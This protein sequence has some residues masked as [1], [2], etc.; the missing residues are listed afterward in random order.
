MTGRFPNLFLVG[1]MR[2]G[3]TAL[4][5]ALDAHPQIVMS[6]FKEPAF[7]ADPVELAYD[8][9]IVSTAGFAGDLDRYLGLFATSDRAVYRGES[10]T[11]YT[12]LPRITGIPERIFAASPAAR[13]VYLVRDPIE[14]TLSHY[15]YAVRVKEET[16]PCLVAV[17]SDPI[18]CS[19]SDYA[20]QIAPYLEL[21]GDDGVFVAVLEDLMEA[22]E[23][24]LTSL[25]TWLGL[26]MPDSGLPFLR[27]N[28]LGGVSRARGPDMLHRIGRTASYQRL[29][30]H[31]V[32]GRVRTA[33]RTRLQ[34]PV[35]KHEVRHP[36]VIEYLRAVHG[37]QV[38]SFRAL[39]GRRFERWSL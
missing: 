16:R 22:P 20:R 18:Y 38:A 12:K 25:L 27:R 29:A 37:P 3:T 24:T 30:R 19:V 21:F 28:A 34:E 6:D 8:S 11:H 17:Q 35:K 33:V 31:V 36:A 32:P 26:P 39:T 7:F 1:A 15:R 2:A 4:H 14:R 10:S 23:G 9:R 13:I 5:E